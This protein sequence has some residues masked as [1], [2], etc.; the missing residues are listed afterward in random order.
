[1]V[2]DKTVLDSEKWR[3]SSSEDLHVLS[4]CTI[5]YMMTW[6]VPSTAI[7]KL[8]HIFNYHN[9]EIGT[10]VNLKFRDKKN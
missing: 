3:F 9:Y 1:M 2:L 4:I 6:G 10:T 5:T 8:F 7:L